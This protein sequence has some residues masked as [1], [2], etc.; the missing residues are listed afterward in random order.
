MPAVPPS[1]DQQENLSDKYPEAKIRLA[2]ERPASAP[3]GK[4]C[5]CAKSH[6]MARV[7]IVVQC[8]DKDQGLAAKAGDSLMP[9]PQSVTSG[10]IRHALGRLQ[11]G[12]PPEQQAQAVAQ[13][14]HTGG[15]EE[16]DEPWG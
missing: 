6:K 14:L 4:S 15:V 13:R 9:A 5:I 16:A 8:K 7:C 1:L 10:I 12:V 11:V 2:K 3:E